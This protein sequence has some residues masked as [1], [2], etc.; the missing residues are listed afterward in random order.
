MG[1]GIIGVFPYQEAKLLLRRMSVLDIY[2][3]LPI[4]HYSS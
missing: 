2:G 4:V 1:F 3:I